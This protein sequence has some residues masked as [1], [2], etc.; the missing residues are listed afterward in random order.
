MFYDPQYPVGKINVAPTPTGSGTLTFD[1]MIPLTSFPTLSTSATLAPGVQNAIQNNLALSL[2]SYFKDAT[3]PPPRLMADAAE[4]KDFLRYDSMT[5]RAMLKRRMI[6]TG[7]QPAPA[8]PAPA[9]GD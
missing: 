9:S 2:I 4:G 5:S 3:N 7:R 8:A 1:S 6:S